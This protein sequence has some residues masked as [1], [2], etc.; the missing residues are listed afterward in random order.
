MSRGLLASVDSTS[1]GLGITSQRDED[2]MRTSVS[3]ISTNQSAPDTIQVYIKN[4]GQTKLANFGKW[5]IIIHYY[6]DVG[7][8]RVEWLPYNSGTLISNEWQVS[9][10]Y[11]DSSIMSPEAFDPNIL[12]PNEEMIITCKLEHPI[13]TGTTN[14]LLVSTPNGVPMSVIFA[15]T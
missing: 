7:T 5:D 14:L 8:Y 4:N 12:N 2:I 1:Q 13:G 15:G 3:M 11:I 6:D 9:G 10:I